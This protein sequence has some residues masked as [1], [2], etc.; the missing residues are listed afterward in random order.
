MRLLLVLLLLTGCA[1]GAWTDP[2]YRGPD[3]KPVAVQPPGGVNCTT[4]AGSV[5]QCTKW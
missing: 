4:T 5:T 3:G 2:N 1:P